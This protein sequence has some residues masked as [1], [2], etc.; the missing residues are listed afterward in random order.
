MIISASRRT[1]IPSFYGDWFIERLKEGYILIQNPRVADRLTRI[2]INRENTDCIVFWTKNAKDFIEKLDDIDKL[3][4]KYCFEYTLTGYGEDIEKNLPDLDTRIDTFIKLSKRVNKNINWRYDPIIL[5]KKYNLKYHVKNF[6]YISK[7][8][9]NYTDRCRFSFIDNYKHIDKKFRVLS[10][11]EMDYLGRNFSKIAKRDNIVLSTC[12][13]KINLEKYGIKNGA[14]IEKEYIENI[15]GLKLDVKKDKNQRIGCKCI[16]T[17]DIGTYN[18]CGNGCIY[19]Y[20]NYKQH[21]K[22]NLLKN[23]NVHSPTLIGKPRGD[24]IITNRKVKSLVDKQISF[25]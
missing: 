21:D 7:K 2:D 11:N 23:H 17:I 9:K 5:N 8:L 19:C 12:C 25:L 20:A 10:E 14:C 6:D 18:T 15:I 22:E 24:E 16:E 3:G 1:D 4:Y 13:E